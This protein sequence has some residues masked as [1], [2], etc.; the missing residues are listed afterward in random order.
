MK[1][2]FLSLCLSCGLVTSAQITFTPAADKHTKNFR[3]GV[4]VMVTDVNGDGRDDI[5]RM[6]DARYVTVTLQGQDGRFITTYTNQTLS[7]DQWNITGGD[8]KNDGTFDFL[9]SGVYDR[10]K[11]YRRDPFGHTY[12]RQVIADPNTFFAQAASVAD[13]NNDG[14]LDLFICNDDEKSVIYMNDGAGGLVRNTQIIDFTTTPPSDNSGNYGSLWCDIDSDGDLDLYISK[15][16]GGVQSPSDPRRINMLFLNNGDGTFT[17]AADSFNLAIGAQSWTAD[18]GDIDNDGDFD[19]FITNHDVPSQLMINVD[20]AYFETITLDA[21]I[22][23]AGIPIQGFFRD[24]DNDGWLDIIVTGTQNFLYRNMGNN[25]FERMGNPFP[26]R[27]I[28]SIGIGDL[29][30]DGFLDLYGM[31]NVL[32]NQPSDVL[33]DIILFNNGNENN[34]LM[35]QLRGTQSNAS[36]IGARLYLH[37]AWG[38][39]TREVRSGEGYGVTNSLTQHFGIGTEDR[40]DSLVIHWPSGLRQVITDIDANHT[41]VVVED[42][43]MTPLISLEQGPYTQ[44]DK[45][46]YIL[47]APDGFASYLWSNGEDSQQIQVAFPTAYHV[48]LTDNDGCIWVAGPVLISPDTDPTQVVIAVDGRVTSCLG[49]PVVLSVQ[50]GEVLSYLWS[51]GETTPTI[52]AESS[53]V[54]SVEVQFECKTATSNE[55][56]VTVVDPNVFEVFNDTIYAPGPGQLSGIGEL[57]LWYLDPG[58]PAPVAIGSSFTTPPVEMTTTFYA[59]HVAVIPGEHLTGG[60]PNHTGVTRYN[61]NQTNGAIRFDVLETFTLDSVLVITEFAGERMIIV[62]N[63][64]G[65]TVGR[66]L[67]HVDSGATY[68]PLDFTL[69]PGTDYL[70]TTD[71]AINQIVFGNNSPRLF[72]S[73]G[74][75]LYPMVVPDVLSIRGTATTQQ[76]YY[77]FYDWHITRSERHCTGDLF[78]VQVVV[79]DTTSAVFTPHVE[80]LHVMPNPAGSYIVVGTPGWLSQATEVAIYDAKGLPGSGWLL[81]NG[82]G[83]IAIDAL[84]HGMYFVR[85]MH[86][87]RVYMGSFIKH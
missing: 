3:S 12:N 41:Y 11:M 67:I 52:T 73:D 35:F 20:N 9:T 43:C 71:A 21:G 7:G 56:T 81:D 16:R 10:L 62:V 66:R 64:F 31:F 61:N 77:Y 22:A 32:Y 5:V 8:F 1:L 76:F 85:V 6:N 15:C 40:A 65:D 83:H 14:W 51:T 19:V 54:Y 29:N 63:I 30:G 37:G 75:F 79:L 36:A 70:L 17:E 2:F 55:I 4:G 27:A 57:I 24:F 46:N 48:S 47:S 68:L 23:V 72:R 69:T 13:I 34:H 58:A 86:S 28:T 87:G 84:P 25:T 60:H 74:G 39:Q 49:T 33:D 38:K 82:A 59:Q 42:G 53:G 18:F 45:E 50:D 44:C 78:P 26:G 80:V